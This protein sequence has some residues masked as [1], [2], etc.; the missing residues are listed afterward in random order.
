MNQEKYIK[1]VLKR[2]KCGGKKKKEIQRD[3]ESD[4]SGALENGENLEDI[5][6][7]MGSPVSLAGEFNEN[8]SKEEIAAFR[9]R[10][11]FMIAGILA[12][13]LV[14]VLLL[15]FYALP[16]NYPM[17]KSGD[18]TEEEVTEQTEKVI[19]YFNEE[20]YEAI[21]EMCFSESMKQ[22]MTE[23]KLSEVKKMFG[24]DWGAFVNYGNIYLGEV[25]QMGKN[26]AVVQ[27]NATYENTGITYT[28][29]FDKEMKLYGF[30][31]K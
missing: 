25:T 17:G 10:K 9:R 24:E 22:A 12:G 13:V 20:N 4:I 2:L 30:Y 6:A 14:V 18:F 3:L 26:Y 23:E 11:G 31:M 28:L 29:M 19:S 15:G 8:F 27:I 5:M 16:K 7:Q 21:Q 1:A